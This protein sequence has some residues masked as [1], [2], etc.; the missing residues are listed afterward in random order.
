MRSLH[1]SLIFIVAIVIAGSAAA[2]RKNET[3]KTVPVA[4]NIYMLEGGGGNIGVSVGND[5]ILIIDDKFA[6]LASKIRAALT[7]LHPG[8]LE[9]ILNTHHH[10]DH[11][12]GNAP[13]SEEAHIIAHTNVRARL[14]EGR[15]ADP[16]ALPVITYDESLSLH[17]NGEEIKVIHF[18]HGHTDS[19]SVVFFT[20]SNVVHMG[21]HFFANRFPFID[22]DG[23]GDVKGYTDNVATALRNLPSDVTIIPGHGAV[24]TRKGLQ[25]F[26]TMLIECT[27]LVQRQI[28]EGKDLTAILENGVP[29]KYD[30]WGSSFISTDRWLTTL[31]SGLVR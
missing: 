27:T 4:G 17:F 26:H 7:E 28:D 11:T 12:G 23:G 5:G 2:Q 16:A 13:L 19:D 30:E 14:A 24:S 31:H 9:F 10:G 3:I 25:T 20:K 1:F 6:P 15:S 29:A 18:P 21:D 22:L 8:K